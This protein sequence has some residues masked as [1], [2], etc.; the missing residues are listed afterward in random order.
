MKK[1]SGMTLFGFIFIAAMLGG[2]FLVSVTLFP[3][4]MD[5]WQVKTTIS[6]LKNDNE[7]KTA[8]PFSLKSRLRTRLERRLFV[9]NIRGIDLKKALEVNAKS[10]GTAAVRLKYEERRHLL[11]NIDLVAQFHIKETYVLSHG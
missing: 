11:G 3:V 8:T 1:Q 5:Y 7:I 4:Y 10:N 6:D 9:D 2:L